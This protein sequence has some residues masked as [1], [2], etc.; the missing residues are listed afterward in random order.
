M[1][2][3]GLIGGA[4]AFPHRLD[5]AAGQNTLPALRTLSPHDLLGGKLD[6]VKLVRCAAAVEDTSQ[7]SGLKMRSLGLRWYKWRASE[8]HARQILL[9]SRSSPTARPNDLRVFGANGCQKVS[10]G[11]DGHVVIRAVR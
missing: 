9:R 5:R 4:M 8:H 10:A 1:C 11:T 3:D 6:R 7:V 2:L